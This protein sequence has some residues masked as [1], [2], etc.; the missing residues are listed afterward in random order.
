MDSCL[1]LRAKMLESHLLSVVVSDVEAEDPHLNAVVAAKTE[2][3][4][5]TAA[6]V[7]EFVGP[8]STA[9]A[10]V[11][12]GGLNLA[13]NWFAVEVSFA[14]RYSIVFVAV[15]VAVDWHFGY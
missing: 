9:A 2:S 10:E 14:V 6:A 5:P 15:I 11:S 3:L 12:F 8:N 4:K 7:E 1:H 13:A